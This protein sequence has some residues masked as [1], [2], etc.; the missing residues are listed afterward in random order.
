MLQ[1]LKMNFKEIDFKNIKTIKFNI[2]R[3]VYGQHITLLCDSHINTATKA[4]I[5]L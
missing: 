5:Y 3:L 2:G 1:V 4:T